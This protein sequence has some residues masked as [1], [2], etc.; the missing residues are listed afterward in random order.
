MEKL[1]TY[2]RRG[3]LA[4]CVAWS[5]KR[6]YTVLCVNKY[7]DGKSF[8]H[9]R[10]GTE[11]VP[12]LPF[13]RSSVLFNH[14]A[15]TTTITFYEGDAPVKHLERRVAEIVHANPWLASRLIDSDGWRGLAY[16]QGPQP[17]LFQELDYEKARVSSEVSLYAMPKRVDDAIVKLGRD[18]SNLDY[19]QFIVSVVRDQHK[20]KDRFALIVSLSHVLGDGYTFYKIHNML[21]HNGKV[22]AMDPIRKPKVVEGQRALMG[23]EEVDYTLRPVSIANVIVGQAMRRF[24]DKKLDV[25]AFSVN[26]DWVAKEKKTHKAEFAAGRAEAPFISTNDIVT[27]WFFKLVNPVMAFMAIN[28]RNRVE[29]CLESDAGNYE[30]LIPYRQADFQSPAL[31]RK[32]LR[33]ARR[34]SADPPTPLPGFF[35]AFRARNGLITNWSTFYGDVEFK[36]CKQRLHYPLYDLYQF[37]DR[38]NM[39]IIFKPR[40]DELG[41]I[42]AGQ[43][44]L[45]DDLKRQRD[46]D[47]VGIVGKFLDMN[48]DR[49]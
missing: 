7:F 34:A 11:M 3:L 24:Y 21:G 13:E 36:D 10:Y 49:P 2:F 12:L 17:D 43:P 19:P 8:N 30:S 33:T 28:F 41:V 4:G 31:I 29:D 40:K 5:A 26:Q 42:M 20:P 47:G 27:S 39:A 45:L 18:V 1:A 25:T 23:G 15:P 38:V 14:V 35:E 48:F 32:S 37:T 46:E 6:L 16:R 22:E 44:G 9:K